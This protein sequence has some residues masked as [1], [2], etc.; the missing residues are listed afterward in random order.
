VGIWTFRV[1]IRL[2]DPVL[3]DPIIAE[4]KSLMGNLTSYSMDNANFSDPFDFK[5]LIAQ[6]SASTSKKMI[7]KLQA[8]TKNYDAAVYDASVNTVQIRQAII[9]WKWAV[10]PG[11]PLVY[12]KFVEKYDMNGDGRL[13]P[14]E[15][16]LGSIYNNP[17]TVGSSLCKHCYF[18]A[19]KIFDAI[20]LY[21]DCNNDGLLSAE[22]MWR[23]LAHMKRNGTDKW[24]IFS[25]GN[26]ENI[27]TSA[28][29]DFILKN[30]KLKNGKLTRNE[31]RVGVLLG[32]WDRQAETTQVLADDSRNM[33]NLRWEQGDM[34][35][36]A[37]YNYYKKRIV[38]KIKK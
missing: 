18:D 6:D 31:F 15:M 10:N 32:L 3:R 2:L 13:N 7:K 25:F 14:R 27:R 23:N 24:N 28:I 30:M 38:A 9:D 36:I 20:F 34:V 11:D 5:K 19:G 37:L 17:Q 29:N 8:F 4:F 26:S 22:E 21:L 35:D 33:K 12:Q 16:I 1:L